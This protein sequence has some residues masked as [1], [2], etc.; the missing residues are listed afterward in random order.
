TDVGRLAAGNLLRSIRHTEGSDLDAH[1]CALRNAWKKYNNQGGKMD[2]SEFR[3]IVLASMPKDWMIFVSTLGAYTTS[4][5]NQRSQLTCSNPLCG[6][7]GH[8]IDKCFKPGGGMEGQYPDWWKKKG[9]ANSK[10]KP[11]ANIATTDVTA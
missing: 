6:C 8:T 9:T 10:S 5:E 3:M 4:T 7:T 1:F 2:D 11:T